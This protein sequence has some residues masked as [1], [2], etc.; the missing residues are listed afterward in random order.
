MDRGDVHTRDSLHNL[1]STEHLPLSSYRTLPVATAG[2]GALILM[3]ASN[4]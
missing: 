1:Q 2:I 3:Y 4:K